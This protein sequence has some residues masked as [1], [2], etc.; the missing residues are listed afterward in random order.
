LIVTIT[1]PVPTIIATPKPEAV[2]SSSI[3]ILAMTVMLALLETDVR[4]ATVFPQKIRTATITTFV[5]TIAAIPKL[6][7]VLIPTISYLAVTE[8]FALWSMF[9]RTELALE[10]PKDVATM[11]TF[12]LPI[13]ATR[14][15][16][17]ALTL[18]T[19]LL[20]PTEM[21]ALYKIL[22]PPALVFLVNQRIATIA[23][24]VPTT[25]AMVLP[26]TVITR[27]IPL[28]ATMVMLVLWATCART[29][30]VLPELPG[31][32]TMEMV[33]PMILAIPLL[34]TASS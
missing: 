28:L 33:V 14:R 30:F 8:T 31:L 11:E 21:L 23:T 20:A 17:I 12:A 7:N 10:E 25:I 9:V 22:V 32:V 4:R 24:P 15:Q 6:D 26:E 13:L 29:E 16:A 5:P 19:M 3:T 1:T 27:I 18:T 34:E 2:T